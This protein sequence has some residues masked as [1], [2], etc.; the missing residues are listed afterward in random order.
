MRWF[1]ELSRVEMAFRVTPIWELA[2]SRFARRP[3][4]AHGEALALACFLY[5]GPQAARLLRP[6]EAASELVNPREPVS[7][8]SSQRSTASALVSLWPVCVE[9]S[10]ARQ[11][12]DHRR[13]DSTR[14]HTHMPPLPPPPT[15]CSA[16]SLAREPKLGSSSVASLSR[17]CCARLCLHK[18]C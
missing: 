8:D 16:A 4:A 17:D 13:V 1:I 12:S 11:D 2:R 15:T 14:L 3:E 6:L 18:Q 9:S 5:V 10:E 7:E